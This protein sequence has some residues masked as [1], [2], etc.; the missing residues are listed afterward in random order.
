MLLFFLES[1][2]HFIQPAKLPVTSPVGLHLWGAEPTS[3]SG[4]RLQPGRRVFPFFVLLS[5]AAVLCVAANNVLA[6]Q[7]LDRRDFI[8]HD[9]KR[10]A[11]IHTD[12]E[13]QF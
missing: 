7:Q 9:D 4:A 8:R 11:I 2:P 12:C 6:R 1:A 5:L 13:R 10:N 3:L